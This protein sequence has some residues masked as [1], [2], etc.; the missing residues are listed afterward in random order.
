MTDYVD[1]NAPGLPISS[2]GHF[3][4]KYPQFK[5]LRSPLTAGVMAYIGAAEYSDVVDVGDDV[6]T[7]NAVLIDGTYYREYRSFT[8]GE[9][10]A[11]AVTQRDVQVMAIQVTTVSG[12]A[13]D[14]CET[15]Q[16]RMARAVAVGS[17][18]DSTMWRLADDSWVSVTWEEL[19]EALK[20]AGT[21]QTNLWD[22]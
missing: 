17:A 15:S 5:T 9:I 18:G 19:K 21:E 12:K 7:G 4:K 10:A 3:A 13:F 1:I 22:I 2:V 16:N 11:A 14:G 8:A 6:A 20:L